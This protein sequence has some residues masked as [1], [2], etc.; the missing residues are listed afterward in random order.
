MYVS[1]PALVALL[2]GLALLASPALLLQFQE[3]S[4]C[5]NAVEPATDAGRSGATVPVFQY[6]EL[7]RDAQRV[8]DRARAAD[9]SV[10][11]HGQR[12]PEA[13][14][15]TADQHRYAIVTDGSRYVLTT[16][17][18]DLVPE[19]PIAAGGLAFLGV[20]LLGVGLTTRDEPDAR[21]PVWIGVVSLTTLLAV[22]AAVVLDRNVWT[23]IGGTGV[24]TALA[25]LGVGVALPTRRALTLGGVLAL[26]P[27]IVVLPLTG[28][29]AVFL[30]PA[31][32]PLLLV[33]IGIGGGRLVSHVQRGESRGA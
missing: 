6:D 24:V 20:C 30:A 10:V 4:E 7:S 16:Y 5:A 23:A 2:V 25:F 15:Y 13:F 14:S 9:G 12:C 1:R 19:V 28:A 22:T 29:S 32:L 33:G 31:V 21:F 17:A 11:V 3:P 27:G 8:F 18:N 26:L